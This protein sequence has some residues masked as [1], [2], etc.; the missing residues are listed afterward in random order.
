M[1]MQ[2]GYGKSS[3]MKEKL[4]EALKNKKKEKMQKSLAE[5]INFGGKFKKKK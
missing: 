5:K 3:S 2:K 1:P 4:N